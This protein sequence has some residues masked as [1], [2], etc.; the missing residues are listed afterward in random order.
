M[1]PSFACMQSETPVAKAF[2]EDATDA[3]LQQ[4]ASS[5]GGPGAGEFG[6]ARAVHPRRVR[7]IKLS[8]CAKVTATGLSSLAQAC[9]DT[10]RLCASGCPQIGGQAFA[11]VCRSL[12]GLRELDVSRCE[13]RAEG[14][15][16]LAG[17]IK[18]HVS[19]LR[20][21]CCSCSLWILLL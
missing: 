10:Q 6:V 15:K 13:L 8:G 19:A 12:S 7:A 9:P 20:F 3:A 4:F 16:C 14:A 1:Q 2:G 17:T 18:D 11:T 5:A 21:V